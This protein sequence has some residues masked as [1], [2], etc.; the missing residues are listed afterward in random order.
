M[1]KAEYKMENIGHY[2]LA[3]NFYSH[4]T[5]P[6]RRYPDIMVHRLLEKHLEKQEVK[7]SITITQPVDIHP[8]EN[9]WLQKQSAILL[10]L[11]KLNLWKIR[12]ERF[13][14]V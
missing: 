11:C 9:S 14:K 12:L 7:E 2:G 8:K 5:S 10:N 4:F 1:S 6:I 3:F 13:L